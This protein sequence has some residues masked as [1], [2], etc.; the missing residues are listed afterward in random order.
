MFQ[1]TF[2][3][4]RLRTK[5]PESWDTQQVQLDSGSGYNLVSRHYVENILDMKDLIKPVPED[6]GELVAAALG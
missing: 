2:Q 4:G 1:P 5:N 3:I 6:F